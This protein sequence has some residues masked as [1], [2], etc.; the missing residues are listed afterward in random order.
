M[1]ILFWYVIIFIIWIH[2]LV[3]QRYACPYLTS[4]LR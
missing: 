2:F 4:W 3:T 1:F